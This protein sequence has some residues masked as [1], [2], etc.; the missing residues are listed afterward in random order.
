MIL[1]GANKTPDADK[2]YCKD[3][4]VASA[5]YDYELIKAETIQALTDAKTI[6]EV[7]TIM[8]D[9]D[10]RL[11]EL[12]AKD[13]D[14]TALKN[15]ILKY[16]QA[17]AQYANEQLRLLNSNSTTDVKTYRPASFRDNTNNGITSAYEAGKD[18]LDA[19]TN[20]AA[21]PAAY[22]EAQALFAD[23]KTDAQ[24]RE[25]ASKVVDLIN[26]LPAS[27]DRNLSTEAQ[28]MEAA[29]AYNAYLDLY[30]AEKSDITGY[31]VFDSKLVT[32]KTYQEDAVEDAIDALEDLKPITTA[33]KAAVQEVRDM[34]ESYLE[35]YGIDSALYDGSTDG[36]TPVVTFTVSN[37]D[38][39]QDYEDDIW[40]AEIDDVE[41]MIRKITTASTVAEVQA[42][43][44]AYDALTGSQ[45]RA[46]K[47]ALGEAFLYK[48]EII[49][50]V[51]DENV[52]AYLQDLSIV[53]RSVKTANGNIKV[54]INADVQPILDA[55]YT[56]EYKFYRSTKPRSNYGTA[57]MIKTENVYTNTSGTKGVRYYYKAM[58][59]VKD[60]D[61]NIIATTP[62]SQCKYACRVK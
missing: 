42:A 24:L 13:D 3:Y 12:R 5:A 7:N 16:K 1:S 48:L 21:L 39:L 55:G 10:D 6:D 30:G 17:L 18:I 37:Y 43:A 54:T 23:I 33:D 4:Y 56:V 9:A 44:D 32:L 46:V 57:R 14:T 11:A 53:A 62:L 52:K 58:I 61:G 40:A 26:A 36:K 34:L 59:Q 35:F 31:L 22:E 27:V 2:K 19:V 29:E 47:A 45:Q 25:E 8:A 38:D 41:N 28:F 60:A 51:K 20:E 15:A 49:Q 50:Q